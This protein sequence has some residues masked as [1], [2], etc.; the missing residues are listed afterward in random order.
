MPGYGIVNMGFTAKRFLP[1]YEG[2]E[3]DVSVH[4]L[5][6]KEYSSPSPAGTLPVDYPQPGINFL[7][8]LRYHF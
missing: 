4:N 8:D 3:I 5:F 6:D 7:I 1:G 2:L